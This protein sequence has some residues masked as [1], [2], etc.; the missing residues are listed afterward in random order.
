MIRFNL[1]K[2]TA[3]ERSF[4]DLRLE[5][6][7]IAFLIFLTG[8]FARIWSKRKDPAA[9]LETIGVVAMLILI[10]VMMNPLIR[11]LATTLM[12]YP[13]EKL[14]ASNTMFQMNEA[15]NY[16]QKSINPPEAAAQQ[17][18][19]E[20]LGSFVWNFAEM[21]KNGL[22]SAVLWI[23]YL[24]LMT[25]ASLLALP[26]YFLQRTLII[27]LF[28]FSPIAVAC[29]SVPA[30]RDKGA[31]YLSMTFSVLAWPLGFALVAAMSNVCLA[32]FPQI[33]SS[34]G[35]TTAGAAVGSVI[36]PVVGLLVGSITMIVG[37]VLVPPTALYIFLYGGTLFNPIS[38]AASSL[39][40]AGRLF[41]FKGR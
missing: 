1:D 10:S 33:G 11:P 3:F 16:F 21:T 35:V 17:T 29:L 25:V 22:I 24:F 32:A 14:E 28:A 36:A 19:F 26:F 38:A 37:V 4:D 8:Y 9:H 5:I 31:G 41:A 30:L 6:Y 27:A 40:M 34:A 12:Y 18:F 7:T 20:K 13:A 15:L 2:L 23:L 39:P